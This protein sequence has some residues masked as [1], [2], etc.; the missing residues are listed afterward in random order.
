MK[1][2]F[3][4]NINL[5][6]TKELSKGEAKLVRLLNIIC[7][8]WYFILIYFIALIIFYTITAYILEGVNFLFVAMVHLTQGVFL[9][10]IQMLQKKEKYELARILFIISAYI[11]FFIFSN[12]LVKGDLIEFFYLLIPLFS[13][14]FLTR[15]VYHYLFLILSILAFLLPPFL[16]EGL[17]SDKRTLSFTVMPVLF[18]AIFLLVNFFKNANKR[19]ETLLENEKKKAEEDKIKI[20]QQT[21]E[22]KELNDFQNHFFI[23]VTHELRTP[24]TLIKGQAFSLQKTI[25]DKVYLDKINKILNNT[26]KIE[27]LVNDVIDVAKAE[28]KKLVLNKT[29][30]S[31]NKC[32][33]KIYLSFHPLFQ[34]KNINL[35][36]HLSDQE[37]YVN[38]D[39][40]YFE[41]ALN[42]ILLNASKY[43]PSG[44]KVKLGIN[45][46][47]HNAIIYITDNGIGISQNE[48]KRIFER[49]YQSKNDI[50]KASGSGI[51]LAF[52][53]EI[54]SLHQGSVTAQIN[55][56]KGLSFN[57]TLPLAAN[58]DFSENESRTPPN[59]NTTVLL[60]DDN[61]EMREYLSTVL[62]AYTILEAENGFEALKIIET[63]KIDALV[64][65]YMMPKMDGFE[66]I[67]EIK[68]KNYNFPIIVITARADT[69]SKLDILA[70]GIDD[71]LTKPFIEDELLYRL[72]NSLSNAQNRIQLQS[73]ED[74]GDEGHDFIKKAKEIVEK[75][76]D[77]MD[78]GVND[79]ADQLSIGERSL[80]RKIK[81]L[82]GLTP[83]MFIR[84][85]KLSYTR[86]LIEREA[87]SSMS[88][89]VARVGFKNTTH[90]QKLYKERF[91]VSI[92]L[93]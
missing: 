28:G 3:D 6:I 40:V 7:L 23:N 26:S 14:L 69:K 50:N 8:T 83:N 63:N 68:K 58:P 76:I 43:T 90:L 55:K 33:Q 2:V 1:T 75:N 92:S 72:S 71:Y 37:Q 60:V 51:G 5:G 82:S 29:T 78:F 56:E 47:T 66:L 89:L 88:Q 21:V 53:Q 85:I 84:E 81:F 4:K 54:I 30:Y 79:L 27:I 16:L 42:N 65:D 52:T 9:I 35:T 91:G 31:V 44:G 74:I 39:S 59:S 80:A 12:F 49:F 17:Y 22:L 86:R 38:I 67:Q 70:L 46:S 64:T 20:E 24:L 77:S 10:S 34:E 87:C 61:A 18:I 36:L 13:L 45:T 32:L 62:V 41:R 48:T 19:N 73:E 93:D 15:K 25:K 57:V 11:Q